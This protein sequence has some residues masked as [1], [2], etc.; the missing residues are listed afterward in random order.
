MNTKMMRYLILGMLLLLILFV[1]IPLV[2]GNKY[3]SREIVVR[4]SLQCIAAVCISSSRLG[5][6]CQYINPAVSRVL[7]TVD[8]DEPHHRI[9]RIQPTETACR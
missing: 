2:Q 6:E 1:A 3:A 7:V 9:V 5:E 8:P 4:E